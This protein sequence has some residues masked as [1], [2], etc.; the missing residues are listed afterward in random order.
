MCLNYV[1]KKS[2]ELL[3][4]HLR[5]HIYIQDLYAHFYKQDY[6]HFRVLTC[7]QWYIYVHVPI[8]ICIY[9]YA[10][11]HEGIQY[12]HTGIYTHSRTH[13]YMQIY[14]PHTYIHIYVIYVHTHTIKTYVHIHPHT[15]THINTYCSNVYGRE[16]T[17]TPLIKYA[18]KSDKVIL[19]W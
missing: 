19:F 2:I 6:I 9:M 18:Q 10:C 15:H 14:N 17:S 16:A 11:M 12:L 7:I 1:V 13:I 5:V 3:V 4:L 8:C